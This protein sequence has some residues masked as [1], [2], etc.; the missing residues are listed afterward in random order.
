MFHTVAVTGHIGGKVKC[1]SVFKMVDYFSRGCRISQQVFNESSCSPQL[2]GG[3]VRQTE[4]DSSNLLL[5]QMQY[6]ECLDFK[7]HL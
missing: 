7:W 2:A 5:W 3:A 6:M 4:S 1:T